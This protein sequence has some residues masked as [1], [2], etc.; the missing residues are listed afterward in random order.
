MQ[1][2]FSVEM[3]SG[4]KPVQLSLG[5]VI[6]LI[7]LFTACREGDPTSQR[8]GRPVVTA[9]KTP[10]GTPAKTPP[11]SGPAKSVSP[12]EEPV[13]KETSETLVHGKV[14]YLKP[15]SARS[16]SLKMTF[17]NGK[18][19]VFKPLLKDDF[20][21]RY[22]VAAYRMAK[23]L[24]IIGVPIAAMREMGLEFMALRLD[25][26]SPDLGTELRARANPDGRGRVPGAMIEWIDD[27]DSKGFRDLGG[28]AEVMKWIAAGGPT[29]DAEPLVVHASRMVAFD[30]LIGNWDRFSGGNLYLA[31]G[32]PRLVLLDHNGSFHKWGDV[33]QQ[34]MAALL[35]HLERFSKRFVKDINGLNNAEI[36]GL[37][38]GDPWHGPHRLLTRE[39]INLILQRRDALLTHISDLIR[40]RGEA[41]VLTFP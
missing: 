29:V 35:K 38:A 22:E 34:K 26:Q 31:K 18:K 3:T 11:L 17:E 19:A 28:K 15:L 1:R 27:I 8:A 2:R 9:A 12:Q 21:A 40:L 7:G 23:H 4:V 10:Q 16:F 36:E 32:R 14:A 25:K 37:L 20:R 41:A 33:R 5:I 24:G 30:Y 39:E 6:G 13:A